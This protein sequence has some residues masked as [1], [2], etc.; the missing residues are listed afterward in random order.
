[1]QTKI[2]STLKSFSSMY[3]MF[4]FW[5]LKSF[6]SPHPVG[7]IHVNSNNFTHGLYMDLNGNE[8]KHL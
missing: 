2:Q 4:I 1:M 3:C 7:I 6:N 5:V 8:T